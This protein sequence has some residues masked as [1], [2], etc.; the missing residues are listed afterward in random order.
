MPIS[1]MVSCW[2]RIGAALTTSLKT[3]DS[4]IRLSTKWAVAEFGVKSITVSNGK[5]PV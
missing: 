4:C 5:S 2:E 3:P 1:R